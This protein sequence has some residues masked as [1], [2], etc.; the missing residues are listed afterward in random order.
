[1]SGM[2]MPLVDAPAQQGMQVSNFEAWSADDVAEY[3]SQRGYQQYKALFVKHDLTGQ[4]VI[5]LTP[6]DIEKMGIEIIGHRLGIQ[7]ELRS[8]KSAARAVVRN[9]VIA[10]EEEAFDGSCVKRYLQ[11]CCGLFPLERDVYVLTTTTLKI[12]DYE[13]ARCFRTKCPCMGGS[14]SN[15]AVPL[16]KILGVETLMST[17]GM[18]CFLEHKCTILLAVSAGTGAETEESRVEQKVLFVEGDRGESFANRIRN[19][20]EEYKVFSHGDAD[21]A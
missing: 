1:M 6:P 11:T 8:L 2:E 16:Q 20:I 17:Q 14:W 19:Q 3:F 10:Q 21:V 4:R 18:A 12:K 5:L 9:K 15:D 7:K 13:V